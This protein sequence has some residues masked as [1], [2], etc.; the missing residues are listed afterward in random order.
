MFSRG[1]AVAPGVSPIDRTF[2]SGH[3]L[4]SYLNVVSIISTTKHQDRF[5][6]PVTRFYNYTAFGIA[7]Y[8]LR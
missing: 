4:R 5:N 8:S 1:H 7:D 6:I 2:C 3:S